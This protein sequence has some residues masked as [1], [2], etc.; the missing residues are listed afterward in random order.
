[1]HSSDPSQYDN[2]NYILVVF[3]MCCGI[4]VWVKQGV[5]LG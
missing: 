4:Q 3:F 2:R 5:D 1:L